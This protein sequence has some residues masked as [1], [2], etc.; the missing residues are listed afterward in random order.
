[1]APVQ[2]FTRQKPM[3]VPVI[4]ALS[5][6]ISTRARSGRCSPKNRQD[7]KALRTSCM[8]QTTW[9]RLTP[10]SVHTPQ[11]E[12]PMVR[13]R[14]DHTGAKTQLGGFHAGLFRLRYHSPGP[15][16]DPTIAAVKAS[17]IQAGRASREAFI[18][19]TYFMGL[20]LTSRIIGWS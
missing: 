16:W 14:K 7:H 17:T 19:S 20:L 9:T 2:V 8:P 5:K 12:T 6:R 13:Y 4:A 11:A 1:M 18:C 10:R 3:I 15:N